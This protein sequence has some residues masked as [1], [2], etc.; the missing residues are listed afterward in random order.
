MGTTGPEFFNVQI[1]DGGL[2]RITTDGMDNRAAIQAA[3]DYVATDLAEG[4]FGYV[5]FPPGQYV[6]DVAPP[7][8]LGGSHG[9]ASIYVPETVVL[10]FAPGATLHILDGAIVEIQGGIEAGLY[11]IFNVPSSTTLG[12]GPVRLTGRRQHEVFPEWWGAADT[13]GSFS[14]GIDSTDA[15]Q[16]A[17]NAAYRDRSHFGLP[18]IPVTLTS[19]YQITQTLYVN[20][21]DDLTDG[22]IL[23]GSQSTGTA[24]NGLPT[25]LG[26]IAS[27]GS[28][29]PSTT[30][31]FD[32][33][34]LPPA[35][36]GLSPAPKA[37]QRMSCSPFPR[38][39]PPQRHG[40]ARPQTAMLN[41]TVPGQELG[42]FLPVPR[43][44]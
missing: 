15:V 10:K 6:I 41:P 1:P 35:G 12:E 24:N 3:I 18:P 42:A 38:V 22:F 5:Y 20:A 4:G 32:L 27:V 30:C 17:L 26:A 37:A 29:F 13:G 2:H 19:T 14:D 36:Y 25:L 7:G 33:D 40:G 16:S 23:R 11:P 8:E 39:W 21:T 9:D 28:I 31:Y 34:T 43:G 44:R